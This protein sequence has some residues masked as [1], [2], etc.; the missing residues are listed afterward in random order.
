LYN[1]YYLSIYQSNFNLNYSINDKKYKFSVIPSTGSFVIPTICFISSRSTRIFVMISTHIAMVIFSSSA[2]TFSIKIIIPNFSFSYFGL[3]INILCF[4]PSA[5]SSIFK[6]L[7]LLY[8]VLT[9]YIFF[10]TIKIIYRVLF[11]FLNIFYF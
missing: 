1:K 4:S 6:L 9:I 11:R 2:S 7:L 5:L 8:L 3:P 10:C